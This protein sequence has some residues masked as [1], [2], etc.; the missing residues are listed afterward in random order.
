[1]FDN[2]KPHVV[3]ITDNTDVLSMSRSLGVHKVA[4]C[5]RAAGFE[6]AVIHHASVFSIGEISQL[7]NSIVN[8][9]TLFVGINNFYYSSISNFITQDNGGI[10]LLPVEH[11]SLLPH[12]GVFNEH[13]KSIILKNNPN[14]KLVLGGVTAIDVAYNSIFDYIVVGYAEQSIV[15][16]AKFLLKESVDLPPHHK[17]IYGPVIVND[18]RAI[19]YDFSQSDMSYQ[20]HDVILPGETLMLE[21]GRGCIFQCAFCSYPMNGKKKMDF[22]R[23]MDLIKKE[24]LDNYRRFGVCNYVVVDDTFN[25]SIEKCQIFAEM[26]KSLPFKISWWAYIRLDL[27]AAHPQ[28]ID[29]LFDAGL[30]AALFGI[31]TLNAKTGSVI[32]KGGSRE[33]LLE[34]V[35]NIKNK[36][37]DAV[38]LH[39]SFIFGLPH[40]SMNSIKNT[41]ELLLSDQNPLDTWR[42]F[43]LNIRPNDK[44][45][46]HGFLSDIDTNYK[47]YG[48]TDTGDK[49]SSGTLYSPGNSHEHGQMLW[50][51]QHTNR[52]EIEKFSIYIDQM[53]KNKKPKIS[54]QYAF[55]LAS[56][57]ID[58]D[59]V[60]NQKESDI[61]WNW[62]DKLKL[63]RS[64]EYKK[65]LF[66]AFN[67]PYVEMDLNGID[68]YSAL[69]KSKKLL[70]FAPTKAVNIL[71]TYPTL[72]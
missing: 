49:Q 38:S 7:L 47:K 32:G 66:N 23:N 50:V 61:D 41:A 26:I 30:K 36:Y 8:S 53:R 2:S 55:Y 31:E 60:L 17:S 27:L 72:D 15:S 21:V 33:K 39:G 13:I 52:I 43:P 16:L 28:T 70:D 9:Q 69:I 11:G 22:I 68:S 3:L 18:S 5:L 56:L 51:N 20:D 25:D 1:M 67:V 65:K 4:Y 40:E 44:S 12:G 35:K 29:W 34:T 48:Y 10:E 59:T 46:A 6:V 37:G 71:Q 62:Y 45:Y 42:A 54:G 57:G 64:L 19:G 14:C 63:Q 58:V 24:L